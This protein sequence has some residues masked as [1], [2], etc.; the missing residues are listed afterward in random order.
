MVV[1][2]YLYNF[3]NSRDNGAELKSYFINDYCNYLLFDG[4][5]EIMHKYGYYAS[6]FHDVG[7]VF[8]DQPYI[9]AI[10]SLEG[11]NNYKSVIRDI[12]KKVY[13]LHNSL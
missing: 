5:P 12:S 8:D 3:V 13:E 6:Y 1:F 2:E 7:I 4:S 10:L 9:I 11:N